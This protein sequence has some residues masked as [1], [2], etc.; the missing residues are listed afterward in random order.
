MYKWLSSVSQTLLSK[1]A[2]TQSMFLYLRLACWAA[3]IFI[4]VLPF[5]GVETHTFSTL[6]IN[7]W[8]FYSTYYEGILEIFT[9]TIATAAF[10]LLEVVMVL[11]NRQSLVFISASIIFISLLLLSAMFAFVLGVA[12]TSHPEPMHWVV[13]T[14]SAGLCLVS[15]AF[16]AI[17]LNEYKPKKANSRKVRS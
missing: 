5:L 11:N 8:H 2:S 1:V 13:L 15:T 4:S 3:T 9:V 12:I 7:L 10:N 6:Q 16:A 14:I 17:V